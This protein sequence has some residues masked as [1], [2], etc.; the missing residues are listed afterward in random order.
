VCDKRVRSVC[1]ACA[2]SESEACAKRVRSACPERVQ[3]VC[4][5]HQKI[6]F[7]FY[8]RKRLHIGGESLHSTCLY[9]SLAP[10]YTPYMMRLLLLLDSGDSHAFHA[11]QAECHRVSDTPHHSRDFVHVPTPIQQDRITFVGKLSRHCVG[12]SPGQW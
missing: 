6:V 9:R 5:A 10:I 8:H 3:S 12:V 1:E 2:T 7:N 4:E 11:L